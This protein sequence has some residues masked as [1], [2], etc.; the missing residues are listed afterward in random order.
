MRVVAQRCAGCW[1]SK[2]GLTSAQRHNR[3]MDKIFEQ[4]KNELPSALNNFYWRNGKVVKRMK[5]T[6]STK[7]AKAWKKGLTG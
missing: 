1:G 2:M 5:L 7:T 6:R 4:A 3:R